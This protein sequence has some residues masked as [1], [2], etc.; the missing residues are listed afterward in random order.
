MNFFSQLLLYAG[1]ART[2]E[3]LLFAG[4]I[5]L[6]RALRAARKPHSLPAYA[7]AVT[8]FSLLLSL[9]G[10]AL[11]PLLRQNDWALFFSPVIFAV[12]MAL[13]YC[14]A[15]ILLRQLC[16]RHFPAERHPP[17]EQLYHLPVDFIQ[18]LPD[19]CKFP[20]SFAHPC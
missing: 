15:A 5:G 13:F 9:C 3:N 20:H 11:T 16:P 10:E 8:F 14:G 12:L 4:G 6:S 19:L 17:L 2:A 18:L 1:L 7:A